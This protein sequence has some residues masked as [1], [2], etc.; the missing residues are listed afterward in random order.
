MALVLATMLFLSGCGGDTAEGPAAVQGEEVERLL[1]PVTTVIV[2][3][4]VQAVSEQGKVVPLRS[5]EMVF[6]R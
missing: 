3:K 1:T 6:L 4:V 5:E 2:P